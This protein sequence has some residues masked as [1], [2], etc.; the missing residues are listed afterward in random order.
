MENSIIKD[1][2]FTKSTTDSNEFYHAQPGIS[3][4][5]LKLMKKSPAHYNE[6]ET[7]QTD[8]MH[9]G[10]LYHTFILEQDR[11][12]KEYQ[13]VNPEL[14]PDQ[15]HGMTAKANIAW[16]QSFSNPVPIETLKQLQAMKDVLFAHPYAKSLLTGG[17]FESS[18]YCDMDIGAN[19]RIQVRFRPDHVK[20]NKRIIVDLKTAAD[21]SE[22]GF[23][24][25]AANFDYH[26]QA[27]LYADLME[28]ITGETLG[29][30]FFFV[31]QEKIPPYAFNIFEA[32]PQFRSVG[33]Y[34]YELLLMLYAYCTETD[35]W[36][37]YQ[38]WCQNKYSINELSLPPWAIKPMEYF[39]H[40]L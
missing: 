30:E 8:A 13:I 39:V 28:L 10:E 20:H 27:A 26:I 6:R 32:S 23:K 12:F 11:F 36:P 14:R 24:K 38:I 21:A 2:K 22:D 17:E 37:G 25:G 19:E 4:S 16:L 29:Y 9:F 33:R 5:G 7:G 40:K 15:G 31:A 34:E 18:Y 1:L 3:A 35:N